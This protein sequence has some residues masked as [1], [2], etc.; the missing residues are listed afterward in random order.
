MRKAEKFLKTTA[1]EV[2]VP[3]WVTGENEVYAPRFFDEIADEIDVIENK[4]DTLF[5]KIIFIHV[6]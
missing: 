6:R 5:C 4:K 1:I 3:A 2:S